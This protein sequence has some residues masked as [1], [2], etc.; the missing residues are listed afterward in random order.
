MSAYSLNKRRTDGYSFYCKECANQKARDRYNERR[1][2]PEWYR[3]EQEKERDRHL[4]RTFGINIEQ[5][6]QMLE[7]QGGKCAIC[8]STECKSGYAFAV[9]HCHTTGAIRGL[10]CRDCNTSLGKFN[11]NIETL[12]RAVKYLRSFKE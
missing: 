10:L 3:M 12:Q 6:N 4:R 2:D 1:S 7:V 9:D 11:D 5:Y 8:L